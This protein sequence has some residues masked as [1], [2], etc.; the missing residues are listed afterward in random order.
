MLTNGCKH[1]P[2]K[3]ALGAARVLIRAVNA[4]PMQVLQG[5]N[6]IKTC[7]NNCSGSGGVVDFDDIICP[8]QG[9]N[10]GDGHDSYQLSN[11]GKDLIKE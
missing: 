10:L 8:G 7:S 1:I 6:W 11:R 4:S 5:S 2:G 3:R 9:E